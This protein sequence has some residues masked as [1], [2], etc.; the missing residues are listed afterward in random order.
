MSLN[1]KGGSICIENT[2][3]DYILFG[4][5]NRV[6]IMIPGL[7]DGLK[8][9]R[10]YAL[11]FAMMYREYAEKYR[12]YV[13]S[14][15]NKLP[16]VFSTRAMAKDIAIAM[17][18]LNIE[19]AD[20]LGVSQGGM[21][22]QYLAIDYPEI[23]NKLCLAV[24]LSK[25]NQTVQSVV[26]DWIEMAKSDNY[27]TLFIDTAEKSYSEKYLKKNRWLYPLMGRV[28]KPNSFER[29]IILAN[30]CLKHNAYDDLGK[31][32]APTL[33]IGGADDKI[34]TGEA[35]KE[36]AEKIPDSQLYMYE[37]LGHG[38]YDEAKDFNQRVLDFF[39]N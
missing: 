8:T 10:G 20:V 23:V 9:V 4:N 3:M 15:R 39:N 37:G 31:I 1:A 16:Q 2:E 35:S 36:I 17:K 7:G 34:V 19:K 13:F 32:K 33:V 14:R 5:G 26:S 28:G 29:F 30:A 24:T 25:Q 11:P 21:I 22:A 27:K 38:A 12:V 18:E 6:L